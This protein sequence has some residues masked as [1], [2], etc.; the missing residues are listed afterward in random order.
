MSDMSVYTPTEAGAVHR[1]SA[2]DLAHFAGAEDLSAGAA[3]AGEAGRRL[4]ARLLADE[5]AAGHRVMMRLAAKVD[6]A[7]GNAGSFGGRHALPFDLIAARFA[8]AAGRLM[9]QFRRGALSL[10]AVAGPDAEG[11]GAWIGVCFENEA[12]APPE[13]LERRL[14]RAKAARAACR[15]PDPKSPPP[16]PEQQAALAQADLAARRLAAEAQAANLTAGDDAAARERLFLDQVAAGHRMMMRLAGRTDAQLDRLG[17]PDAEPAATQHIV[18]RLSSTSARLME[19]VRLGLL[20][21][22]R[23]N[24]GP[25]GGPRKVAGYYWTG[26]RDLFADRPIATPANDSGRSDDT[27]VP[28]AKSSSVGAG[29]KP[30]RVGAAAQRAGLKPAPTTS[31]HINLRR[32]RLRN[33]NPS[34][35]YLAA[36]RRGARTRAGCSC[37][38][39]AMKSPGGG[40]GRCRFHGGK[41]TG[42]RTAAGLQRARTARLT[43]GFRSAEIIDLRKEAAAT[44]RRLRTLLSGG[45][46]AGHGVDRHVLRIVAGSDRESASRPRSECREELPLPLREGV[47]GE[48]LRAAARQESGLLAG[49]ALVQRAAHVTHATSGMPADLGQMPAPRDSLARSRAQTP[50]PKP[51]PARGGGVYLAAGDVC[52]RKR[53]STGESLP[54]TRSGRAAAA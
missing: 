5:L 24:A 41:S 50:P 26:E 42:P 34:G 47:L 14:A 7:I 54:R 6:Y 25:G 2:A 18:L 52:L 45:I 9:D 17:A 31:E 22:D 32:G 37:S 51:P 44:G 27:A 53:A 1:Q 39:P 3:V 10:P 23:L 16:T 48:G 11:E 43:H 4:R 21:I 46:P 30:A 28:A 15:G 12:L 29:F 33:G 8:G 13:E 36:P 49:P 38:Q 19:R 40:R 20:A 35:D